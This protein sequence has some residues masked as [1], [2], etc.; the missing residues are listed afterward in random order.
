MKEQQVK[1][2]KEKTSYEEQ[3]TNDEIHDEIKSLEVLKIWRYW[4]H[5]EQQIIKVPATNTN[6]YIHIVGFY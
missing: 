6:T 3:K 2:G 4:R 5:E 1:K